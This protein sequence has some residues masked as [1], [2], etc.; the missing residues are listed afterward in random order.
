MRAGSDTEAIPPILRP[1]QRISGYALVRR[2]GRGGVAE[3][4]EA[5]SPRGYRLALKLV[6]LSTDLRSGELRA[7]KITRGIRHPHL[8][9]IF[10][11]WQVENLLVIS[12]ELADRSLWD[13]FV[14]ANVQGLRGIPR[15]EL[16]GYLRPV[17][18]AIDYL[19]DYRHSVGGRAGVGVQHRD[20]KPH[21]ILL[22]GG[23]AKVADFGMARIMERSIASHT[24]PCTLPYA[25]PEYF[26]GQTSRQSDQYALA[27]TYCQLRGGRMPFPGTTAQITVGHLCNEPDL[28][29]LP[30]PER[31]VVAR[32]LAKRPEDRWHDCRSFLDALG[33]LGS[34]EAVNVP[35]TLP[36]ENW[37]AASAGEPGDALH[38]TGSTAADFIPVETSDVA[39]DFIPVEASDADLAPGVFEAAGGRRAAWVARYEAV[40]D[41]ARAAGRRS[42]DLVRPALRRA[43]A[44]LVSAFVIASARSRSAVRGG[45]ASARPRARRARTALAAAYEAMAARARRDVPRW[46]GL[47]RHYCGRARA[48]LEASCEALV[49]R[50]R[51]YAR[52]MAFASGRLA[53]YARSAVGRELA[54]VRARL[55]W[56]RAGRVAAVAAL[57]ATLLG[58]GVLA[59]NHRPRPAAPL[60]ST[61]V[62]VP[63]T[64]RT[65]AVVRHAAARHAAPAPAAADAPPGRARLIP[66]I[67]K[68]LVAT[69]RLGWLD[70]HGREPAPRTEPRAAGSEV[71][72]AA[73]EPQE[74]RGPTRPTPPAPLAR[75]VVSPV[76]ILPATVS[77]RA[78]E[79]AKVPVRVRRG[80][81]SAALPLSFQ[82]LPRGVSAETSTIPEGED[83]ADVVLS[84]D[85][86]A[87]PG[88]TEALASIASRHG[89]AAAR[90]EVRVLPS[91]VSAAYERGRADLTR[92]FYE[93]AVADFSEAIRLD[94]DSFLAH[95]DRGVA[96]HLAG[97]Y[98]EATA[99]YSEGIR[100]KP[101]S[102]DAY[103]YRAR[104]RR[105]LGENELALSDY[106]EAIRLRPDA[107]LYLA[108]GWLRHELGD[109]DRAL[110]DYDVALR[111]RP[112]DPTTRYRRGLTRYHSGDLAGA[113]ADFSAV[114]RR[115]PKHAGAYRYRG[116]V[117]ARL[118]QLERAEADHSAFERLSDP[119]GGG[120][121]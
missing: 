65:V 22:V 110:A 85:A 97:H 36:R 78:G 56:P 79:A 63:L 87:A 39:A 61:P 118:G 91:R 6:H 23:R 105:A 38:S 13:R 120:T 51:P 74:P 37:V 26:G 54:L 43:R 62:A 33:A 40:A 84:A 32:A 2:L 8:L 1:R 115:D 113:I 41:R 114:I 108:R 27:V 107:K 119:A 82:G 112:D 18:D 49:A 20:L 67:S 46:L 7:L 90:V 89:T 24:G 101:R 76:L 71:V 98:R 30:E 3:V 4:W 31:P 64:D 19:N 92:R 100:L 66:R 34:D 35:D 93:R 12:M 73:R 121:R 17:A 60:V 47:V 11:T 48:G 28:E 99:D 111:L 68:L 53:S 5:E 103:E 45:L 14:E 104:A 116:D 10:G 106:D 57:G 15:G 80:D 50:G 117:Y 96:H 72:R 88:T 102:A 59:F 70:D 55:T 95:L 94:P 16:L 9:S 52:R 29:G 21:N 86:D 109:Y 75:A 81:A 25:A 69:S 77:V 42:A 83:R 44:G 58:L